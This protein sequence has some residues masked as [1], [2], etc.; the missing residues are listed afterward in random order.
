MCEDLDRIYNSCAKGLVFSLVGDGRAYTTEDLLGRDFGTIFSSFS[1]T[2]QNPQ[3]EE[4]S[5]LDHNMLPATCCN[6]FQQWT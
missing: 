3:G 4:F 5:L 2:F 1:S 6:T